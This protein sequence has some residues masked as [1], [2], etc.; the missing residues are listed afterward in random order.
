MNTDDEDE[1]EKFFELAEIMYTSYMTETAYKALGFPENLYQDT[2]KAKALEE[3]PREILMAALEKEFDDKYIDAMVSEA[4]EDF[5]AADARFKQGGEYNTTGDRFSLDG[6]IFTVGLFF[7]GIATVFKSRVR[8]ILVGF[9]GFVL[10]SA[11][12]YM[13]SIP[14]A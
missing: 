8:W 6:V 12:V 7:A 10:L 4:M 2:P 9:A 1:K 5:E 11:T 13:F 14:W 3:M